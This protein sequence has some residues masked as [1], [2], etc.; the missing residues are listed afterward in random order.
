MERHGIIP[1]VCDVVIMDIRT[2]LYLA[3]LSA[4]FPPT[5]ESSYSTGGSPT[6]VN[7]AWT[8]AGSA[9]NTIT[10]ALARSRT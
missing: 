9:P 10:M 7:L 4:P 1:S 3:A 6:F 8:S 2:S 5:E